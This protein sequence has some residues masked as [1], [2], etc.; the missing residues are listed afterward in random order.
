MSSSSESVFGSFPTGSYS[1]AGLTLKLKS[2]D[3]AKDNRDPVGRAVV[4]V[5]RPSAASEL[6]I[7]QFAPLAGKST[8]RLLEC[9]N[10]VK[11]Y[12]VLG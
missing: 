5:I 1:V 12:P 11:I 8:G 9:S 10:R 2:D 6:A 3:S 7:G 4:L